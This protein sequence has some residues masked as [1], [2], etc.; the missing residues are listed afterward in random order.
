MNLDA[1][2]NTRYVVIELSPKIVVEEGRT[3]VL[4]AIEKD[5]VIRVRD[6]GFT[7]SLGVL[8]EIDAR[9]QKEPQ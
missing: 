2:G 7:S 6:S 8:R 4:G 9:K 3:Y 5:G 1:L